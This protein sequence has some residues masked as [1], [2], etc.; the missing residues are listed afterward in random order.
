MDIEKLG[1][2]EVVSSK[3]YHKDIGFPTDVQVPIGHMDLEYSRHAMDEASSDKYSIGGVDLP[4]FID[5]QLD[6]VI[7]IEVDNGKILKMVVRVS[8]DEEKDL[9]LAIIPQN[10]LVKTVWFNTRGDKHRTLD[11]WRY[12]NPK[13]VRW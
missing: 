5:F 2:K 1:V 10:G 6:N 11:K 3:L 8:Y 12:T 4:E 7:E 13:Q 9:V